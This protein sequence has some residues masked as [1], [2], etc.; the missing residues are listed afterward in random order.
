MEK[1]KREKRKLI[2]LIKKYNAIEL[3]MATLNGAQ[4]MAIIIFKKLKKNLPINVTP[5]QA[6]F[7][8]IEK[9]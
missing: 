4:R 1:K 9:K 5:I 6:Q 8:V 7:S 2:K 3:P